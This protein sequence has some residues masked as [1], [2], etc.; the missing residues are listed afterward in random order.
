MKAT[1]QR[2]RK[3]RRAA[4]AT[5]K[6]PREPRKPKLHPAEQY[7]RDIVDGKIVASKY[8]RQAAQR[9]F[10]DLEYGADRGLKFDR[11]AAQH[12]IDFFPA[13]LTHQEGEFA[14]KPFHLTPDQQAKVWIVYGW[15]RRSEERSRY[16]RRF[17]FVYNEEGR[18]NGKSMFVSGLCLYELIAFGEAGAWV[19]SAA[20]D[21]KTARLVW[22]T[23]A[24][25]VQ[26]NPELRELIDKRAGIANMHV[27]GTAAKFEAVASDSDNLLGLRPQ[28]TSL[29]EL[30]VHANSGVWDV[31]ESAMGKRVEPLLWAIT[32][33]GYDRL[34]V[35]WQKR[36]Y[37]IKVLDA[38][39]S[40]DT[41]F[42]ND[43]WFVWICGIDEDDDWEDETCWRKAN[44]N[45]GICVSMDELR[46]KAAVAKGDPS[47]LNSFL[48]F[49][50]SRW[51]E[52][53]ANWMPMDKWDLC[54]APVDEHDL[55]GRFCVGALDL[56]TT[57][58]ISAFALIFPPSDDDPKWRVL[59]R[60]FLP[61]DNIS[62][63]VKRDRVPYDRWER[64]GGFILTP[65]TVIDYG[66][67]RAEVNR[68][69]EMF[70]LK[71]ISYDRWNS[72]DVV[73]NLETDGF[74]MIK[75]GQGFN[76]MNAPM[77]RLME[78]VLGSELAHG[79]CPILRWMARNTVAYMDPAGN[80]KPDKAK[81][82]EK[83]DG[84]VATIM[85]LGRAMQVAMPEYIDSDV[86][87]L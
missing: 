63:R 22:D 73:K 29:D 37:A 55:A 68:C 72:S 57:T 44:P 2:E 16:I 27:P 15:Q 33:S 71:E 45:L 3:T 56:S 32:N 26:S 9:H 34:S 77:K 69:A 76:D 70:D 79:A 4:E 50:L 46:Q 60:Y 82:K 51:T 24:Q 21:K 10:Q 36:E 80:I 84:I 62:A 38:E 43:T 83:I 52:G 41:S 53:T 65:G 39:I 54:N 81:S 1:V 47:S 6:K 42:R 8:V 64:E 5:P 11:E 23:A 13:F 85:A 61:K 87:Y 86:I 78:L 40:G 35:C 59:I 28:F 31:F 12:C 49:R 66:A 18:G 30:H 20:T 58:D 19:Y 14:G 17:Q 67:I 25:M 74:D 75:W 48:R 7:L